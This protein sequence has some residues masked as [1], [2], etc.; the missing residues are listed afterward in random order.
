M[1]GWGLSTVDEKNE[2]WLST[3]CAH[4]LPTCLWQ[5]LLEQ[6]DKRV[7]GWCS[8]GRPARGLAGLG[9]TAAWCGLGGLLCCIRGQAC[10]GRTASWSI[11]LHAYC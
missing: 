8:L 7:G 10:R 4:S 11:W 1:A 5:Q 6:G 9:A 3:P 2:A